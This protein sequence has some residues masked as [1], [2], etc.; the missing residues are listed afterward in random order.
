LARV[1]KLD[2]WEDVWLG[3]RP[4]AT[5]YLSLYN[6]ARRKNMTVAEAINPKH[7]NIEFRRNLV[8]ERWNM[9]LHLVD[10]LMKVHLNDNE[11]LF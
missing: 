4:L 9:W 7:L 8:G 2:F 3:D 1:I 5:Q 6:E 11:D 10:R